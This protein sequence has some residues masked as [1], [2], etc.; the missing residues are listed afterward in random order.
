MINNINVLLRSAANVSAQ[1][2]Q[3]KRFH[4][5]KFLTLYYMSYHKNSGLVISI[6]K[7]FYHRVQNCSYRRLGRYN[8]SG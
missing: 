4:C 5:S 8:V 6:T 2:N 1:K 7:S 3:F